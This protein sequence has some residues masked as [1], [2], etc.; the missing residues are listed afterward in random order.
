MIH[1]RCWYCNR[2]YLY[3]E[4]E[5]GL[6]FACSCG[7][8]L[9]VPR[10]SGENCRCKGP[11]DFLVEFAVYGFGGAAVG[12]LAG[13]ILV[14]KVFAFGFEW[15]VP[16]GLGVIGFL[17]GGLGGERGINWLGSALRRQDR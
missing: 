7:Q 3:Q 14:A 15:L 1:F 2:R 8:R 13:F 11:A 10:R 16:V 5:A 17:V 9:K 12:L 4:K 6:R